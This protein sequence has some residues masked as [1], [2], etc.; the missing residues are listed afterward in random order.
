MNILI[1]TLASENQVDLSNKSEHI[2]CWNGCLIAT[3]CFLPN[4]TKFHLKLEHSI[5]LF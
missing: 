5:K 4:E 2:T 1:N 3:Y